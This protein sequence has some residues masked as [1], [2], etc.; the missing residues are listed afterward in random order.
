VNGQEL[1]A[2]LDAALDEADS[3]WEPHELPL[4]EMIS[5]S[6]DDIVRL[7]KYLE[8]AGNTVIGSTGQEKLNPVIAE[9]RLQRAALASLLRKLEFPDP[10]LDEEEAKKSPRH[11]AAAR[12]RWSRDAEQRARRKRGNFDGAQT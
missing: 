4:L 6:A 2:Q 8:E 5:A 12:S 11:V 1:R 10:E 3:E 7:E 9:L